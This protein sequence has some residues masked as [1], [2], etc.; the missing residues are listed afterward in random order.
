MHTI[1]SNDMLDRRLVEIGLR[2]TD[3]SNEQNASSHEA[4]TTS[5]S[6]QPIALVTHLDASHPNRPDGVIPSLFPSFLK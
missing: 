5:T 1:S 4:M 3:A 2:Q 6:P